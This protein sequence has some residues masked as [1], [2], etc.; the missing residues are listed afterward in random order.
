MLLRVVDRRILLPTI[1]A[2]IGLIPVYYLLGRVARGV[3]AILAVF[4]GAECCLTVGFSLRELPCFRAAALLA[5]RRGLARPLAHVGRRVRGGYLQSSRMA[6][7]Q[8]F[9]R[10]RERRRSGDCARTPCTLD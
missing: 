9:E 1:G 10:R 8:S 7:N 2:V 6:L 3:L 5:D 4:G